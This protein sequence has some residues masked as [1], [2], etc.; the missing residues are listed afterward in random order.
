MAQ[1]LIN[2]SKELDSLQNSLFKKNKLDDNSWQR[3]QNLYKKGVSKQRDRSR[4]KEQPSDFKPK[5]NINAQRIKRTEK[6]SDIL[7]SD[8]LR[9]KC[10]ENKSRRV[11]SSIQIYEK[12]ENKIPLLSRSRSRIR[13]VS[14][15]FEVNQSKIYST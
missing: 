4:P 5:I 13:K 12:P 2:K 9:R 15:L 1:N 14:N 10:N 6:I 7:Y 3:L 8:A 11:N